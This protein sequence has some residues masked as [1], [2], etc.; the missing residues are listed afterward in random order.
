M[1]SMGMDETTISAHRLFSENIQNVKHLRGNSRNFDFAGLDQK[2][3]LIFIDGEHHHDVVVSDTRNVFE[4][5][6][7]DQ[8][9]VVWHDYGFHPDKVRYEVMAAIL[10]GAGPERSQRIYHVAHTKSAIY[11][12]REFSSRPAESV[13]DPLEYYTFNLTRKTL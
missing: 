3:D 4:H 5:L 13:R 7:H 8:S 1:R 12:G 2:F 6:V 9:I 11:T 10:D